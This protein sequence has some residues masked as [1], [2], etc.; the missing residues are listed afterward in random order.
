MKIQPTQ[1]GLANLVWCFFRRGAA[2]TRVDHLE[3]CGRRYHLHQS[4]EPS[5]DDPC[6]TSSD[7]STVL[8]PPSPS[9]VHDD[10]LEADSISSLSEGSI[11]P[12]RRLHLSKQLTADLELVVEFSVSISC[13][14]HLSSPRPDALS[15]L[16]SAYCGQAV[17][18]TMKGFSPGCAPSYSNS[19][20]AE[21][22]DRSPAQARTAAAEAR[23]VADS[24]VW[25]SQV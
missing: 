15:S 12:I 23:A 14:P 6:P 13:G 10:K 2:H 19:W 11:L 3:K 17:E 24:K 21:L 16:L 18:L 9:C 7:G 4:G 1:W 22:P 25:P 20:R 5:R 8:A